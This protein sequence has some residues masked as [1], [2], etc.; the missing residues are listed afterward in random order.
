[1]RRPTARRA[2]TAAGADSGAHPSRR[3][4]CPSD[5]RSSRQPVRGTRRARRQ[6]PNCAQPRAPPAGVSPRPTPP[7]RMTMTMSRP[8]R[9]QTHVGVQR[10]ELPRRVALLVGVAPPP[11]PDE[12]PPADVLHLRRLH[13][14][15]RERRRPSGPS[16]A[17]GRNPARER[18]RRLGARDAHRPEVH[19]E[20]AHHEHEVGHERGVA[21]VHHP[22]C[23]GGHA[24]ASGPR[25]RRRRVRSVVAASRVDPSRTSARQR[26]AAPG[27]AGARAPSDVRRA[28]R[29]A[30]VAV[31]GR[32]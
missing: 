32:T 8:A 21:G 30:P 29:S 19:G 10:L 5:P 17:F 7:E 20:E 31:A 3:R 18:R 22:A 27:R 25:R 13:G 4:T 11:Q 9:T 26:P 6:S 16:S 12:Q 15:Q 2:R 23:R 1:M 28:A 24:R 14:P